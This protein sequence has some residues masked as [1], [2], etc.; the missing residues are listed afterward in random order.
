MVSP[1]PSRF[2][3]HCTIRRGV[4]VAKRI[5]WCF[6]YRSRG[7]LVTVQIWCR[8][9]TWATRNNSWT[10]VSRC[11]SR[12][13]SEKHYIY[14]RHHIIRTLCR[15]MCTRDNRLSVNPEE[16]A[17]VTKRGSKFKESKDKLGKGYKLYCVLWQQKKIFSKCEWYYY[18]YYYF[19]IFGLLW[20]ISIN[21]IYFKFDFHDHWILGVFAHWK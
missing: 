8:E 11:C 16:V 15:Q 13:G 17:R 1:L 3:A 12:F 6:R 4:K 14:I 10:T 5:E 9:F 19:S 2:D 20:H 18:H 7:V 21:E